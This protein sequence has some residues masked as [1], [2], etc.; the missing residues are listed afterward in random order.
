MISCKFYFL[1]KQLGQSS[2]Q[3]VP[4]TSSG[5]RARPLGFAKMGAEDYLSAVSDQLLDGR[6]CCNHTGLICDLAIL[7][8]YVEIAS[9]Q[10]TLAF[11]VDIIYRFLI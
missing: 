10:D 6:K 9:Y 4:G 5:V 7:Q 1:A 2:L 11:Y 8:R 3:P